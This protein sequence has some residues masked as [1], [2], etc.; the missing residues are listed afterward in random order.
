MLVTNFRKMT[1]NSSARANIMVKYDLIL[2]QI[3]EKKS[4]KVRGQIFFFQ[5]TFLES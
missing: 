4:L 1:N 5:K 2:T 3:H